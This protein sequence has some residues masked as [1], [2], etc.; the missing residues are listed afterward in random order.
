MKK[1]NKI[2]YLTLS[3]IIIGL[4]VL[5]GFNK[6]SYNKEITRIYK[7]FDNLKISTDEFYYEEEK[8]GVK[9]S[10]FLHLQKAISINDS[11]EYVAT[12]SGKLNKS[13]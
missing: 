4:I 3:V 10:G 1:H 5:I 11:T 12:Y 6:T 8:G 9:Y 2:I 13:E 7:N